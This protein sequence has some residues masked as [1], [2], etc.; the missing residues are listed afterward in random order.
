MVKSFMAHLFGM[1]P[2]AAQAGHDEA[3]V[4]IAPCARAAFQKQAADERVPLA[5]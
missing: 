5:R 4:L 3:W 1:S 2:K